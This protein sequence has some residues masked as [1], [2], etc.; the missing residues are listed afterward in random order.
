MWNMSLS[1]MI[2]THC[3]NMIKDE[4]V[5]YGSL[6]NCFVSQLYGR[7]LVFPLYPYACPYF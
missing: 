4:V 3:D 2:T 7:I 5:F 1:P 6:I